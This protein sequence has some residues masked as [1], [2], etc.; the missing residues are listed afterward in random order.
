[1]K[2]SPYVVWAIVGLGVA[3]L[4]LLAFAGHLLGIYV[5]GLMDLR[6]AAREALM[7]NGLIVAI[8]LVYI[9]LLALPFMPGTEIGIALFLIFGAQIAGVIYLA[10][11]AALTLSFSI[12]QL[13]PANSLERLFARLGF[14]RTARLLAENRSGEHFGYVQ[15]ISAQR[16]PR[17]I[18]WMIRNRYYALAVLINIPGNT[19]IGGGGGIALAAGVS[20][21]YSIRKFI[22][23]ISLA[24]SPVPLTITLLAW[25]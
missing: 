8:L 23:C 16:L 24:V 25:F 6:H 18:N 3:C 20:R 7:H 2:L 13:A 12:G 4:V 15:L 14:A 1:M 21:L 17:W 10:T 19:L 9:V 22:I 11:V 5:E